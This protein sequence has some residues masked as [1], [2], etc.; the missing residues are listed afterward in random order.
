MGL[1][2]SFFFSITT[3]ILFSETEKGFENLLIWG[4][5]GFVSR[6]GWGWGV[7]SGRTRVEFE[8]LVFFIRR[9]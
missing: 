8:V 4:F 7:E 3:I 1:D 2:G 6:G 9:D 5:W